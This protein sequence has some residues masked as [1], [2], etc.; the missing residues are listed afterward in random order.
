MYKDHLHLA[1]LKYT[2][3]Y[4][5]LHVFILYSIPTKMLN[6]YQIFWQMFTLV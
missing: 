3:I 6:T 4:F 2:L 1:P 5:I